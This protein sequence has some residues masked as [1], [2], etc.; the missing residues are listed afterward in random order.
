MRIPSLF[1]NSRGT[2]PPYPEFFDAEGGTLYAIGDVHGELNLL[3]KL[4]KKIRADVERPQTGGGKTLVFM[5]DYVDRGPD[6]RGVLEF[7]AELDIPD[8]T[9]VFLR[10][11]HEQQMIDFIDRPFEKKRWLEWGGVET[12]ASFD[13]EP[14]FPTAEESEFIQ[15]AET[16]GDVFGSLRQFIEERTVLSWQTGNIVFSH[17][18]MDPSLPVDEQRPKTMLWG[19]ENFMRFG[20][21][22]G[23]WHVHGHVIH[24]SPGIFGNRIAVDTGAY[25]TG[26]L[27]AARITDNGCAFLEQ[28]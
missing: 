8:C 18:G 19:S 1:G 23:F 22:S 21:P 11:N 27:T 5:G 9:I 7:L 28:T 16:F 6:S 25:K 24:E 13:I 26:V 14:V 17:G 20:G 10:G 15:T 4:V 2:P 12:L 3:E